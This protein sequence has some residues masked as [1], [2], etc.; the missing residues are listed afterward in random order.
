MPEKSHKA[1]YKGK[2][3]NFFEKINQLTE[4]KL[5]KLI[6]NVVKKAIKPLE[7]RIK[8]LKTNL[9]ELVEV[10]VLLVI[11]TIKWLMSPKILRP[12]AVGIERRK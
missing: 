5:K 12:K 1:A 2:N 11:N 6:E 4:N 10:K 9:N 3:D 7:A 8:E